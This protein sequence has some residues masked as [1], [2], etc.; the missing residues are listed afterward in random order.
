M[1]GAQSWVQMP[2]PQTRGPV[3]PPWLAP[4]QAAVSLS[5][6]HGFCSTCLHPPPQAGSS[7]AS[8]LPA[9]TY[10]PSPTGSQALGSERPLGPHACPRPHSSEPQRLCPCP[11]SLSPRARQHGLDWPQ[12]PQSEVF[13]SPL[14]VSVN[15][16]DGPERGRAW[17]SP[18]GSVWL[19]DHQTTGHSGAQCCGA[20][21][22]P[23]SR[24][25][26]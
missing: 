18:L 21:W 8:R 17:P 6:S 22:S 1:Q 23:P 3:P 26:P 7:Q 9:T 16:Q 19:G 10:L 24:G 13:R 25:R 2:R 15:R 5:A 12:G 14:Q 4:W 11:R 20:C